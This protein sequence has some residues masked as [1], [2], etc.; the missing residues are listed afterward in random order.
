M[1]TTEKPARARFHISHLMLVNFVAALALA[2][3]AFVNSDSKSDWIVVAVAYELIILPLVIM[4]VLLASMKPGRARNE[5]MV[6]LCATPFL[7]SIVLVPI[8]F[9]YRSFMGQTSARE[10]YILGQALFFSLTAVPNVIRGR[11]ACPRCYKGEALVRDLQ[12]PAHGHKRSQVHLVCPRC[13]G[14][15]RRVPSEIRFFPSALIPE[16]AATAEPRRKKTP[17]T[18]QG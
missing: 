18:N 5:L 1:S 15:W 8:F 13:G 3:L 2:P 4:L 17:H 9:A 10:C 6:L 14:R 16:S 12:A 7:S 11:N